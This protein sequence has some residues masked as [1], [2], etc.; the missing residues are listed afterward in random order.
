MFSLTTQ[1]HAEA[2]AMS[3]ACACMALKPAAQSEYR[4]GYKLLETF[5]LQQL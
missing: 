3:I 5:D 2:N 4:L 1:T